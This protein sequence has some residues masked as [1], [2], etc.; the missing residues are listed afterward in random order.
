MDSSLLFVLVVIVW[1]VCLSL[2]LFFIAKKLDHDTPW[3]AFVP[4]GDQYLLTDLA[5]QEFWYLWV[6]V[7]GLYV[8]LLSWSEVAE[9]RDKS[10]VFGWLM[11]VPGLNIVLPWYLAIVD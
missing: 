11:I 6:P 8:W 4:I 5:G 7:Y 2:P 3:L 9:L 10:P 1:W